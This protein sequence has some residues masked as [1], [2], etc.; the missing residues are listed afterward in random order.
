[1]AKRARAEAGALD[2]AEA[3]AEGRGK[4]LLIILE[5]GRNLPELL[6]VADSS[7]LPD[8]QKEE[9]FLS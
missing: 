8:S 4:I 1:M 3:R 6:A 7:H 2:L 9:A 5:R